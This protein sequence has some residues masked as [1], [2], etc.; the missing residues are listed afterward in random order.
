MDL[1]ETDDQNMMMLG[2]G[3]MGSESAN[4]SSMPFNMGVFVM[5][6]T[7][8]SLNELLGSMSSIFGSADGAGRAG[9]DY[10]TENMM[11]NMMR[12]Q[13]MIPGEGMDGMD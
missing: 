11:M 6:M 12:Q 3:M 13:M 8:T 5:P 4:M 7:C 9:G 1:I 2:N 10:A